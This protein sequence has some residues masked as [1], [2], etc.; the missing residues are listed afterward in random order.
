MVPRQGDVTRILVDLRGPDRQEALDR[1]IALVYAELRAIAQARLRH[2]RPDHSLEPSAL[3]HEAYCGFWPAITRP[4]TIG[5]ISS[6]PPPR[7][8]AAS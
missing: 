5:G 8:C 7:R 4:G 6:A 1:L 2:E 3:V